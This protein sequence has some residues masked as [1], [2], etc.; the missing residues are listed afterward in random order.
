MKEPPFELP[1][2]EGAH[3]RAQRP[4]AVMHEAG[5]LRVVRTDAADYGERGTDGLYDYFYAFA[6]YELTFDGVRVAARRYADEWSRVSLFP[7]DAVAPSQ[8]A[9][10]AAVR[11]F[12]DLDDVAELTV[13]ADGEHQPLPR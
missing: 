9:F 13:Y 10:E 6:L 12:R 1:V 2:L 4:P 7:E 3:T 11:Y 8:T 5:G